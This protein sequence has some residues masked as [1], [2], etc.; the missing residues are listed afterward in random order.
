MPASCLLKVETE[1]CIVAK[2]EIFGGKD[3]RSSSFLLDIG[4]E[5]NIIAQSLVV[6]LNMRTKGRAQ[7]VS[8]KA[9]SSSLSYCYRAYLVQYWLTDSWGQQ[10]S[11][12]IFY[13]LNKQGL[14]LIL[15]LSV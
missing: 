12:Q 13:S 15:G 4:A 14:P 7:L 11:E 1:K 8:I 9:M 3:W 10:M 5:V 2:G 6:A